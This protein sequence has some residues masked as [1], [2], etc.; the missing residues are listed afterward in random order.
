MA[1]PGELEIEMDFLITFFILRHDFISVL[2]AS[3]GSLMSHQP[4][5]CVCEHDTLS[6]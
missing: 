3:S 5:H 2:E 4:V 6:Q 1:D